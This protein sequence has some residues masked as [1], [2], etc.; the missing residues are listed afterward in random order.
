MELSDGGARVADDKP[1]SRGIWV[2]NADGSGWQM[3]VTSLRRRDR[4][5][6]LTRCLR[7]ER[8]HVADARLGRKCDGCVETAEPEPLFEE[9]AHRQRHWAGWFS[10]RI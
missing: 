4:K 2:Q 1:G 6:I 8:E 5:V 9:L 10:P 3:R 7:A